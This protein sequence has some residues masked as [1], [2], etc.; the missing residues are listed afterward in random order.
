MNK[1]ALCLLSVSLAIS[2]SSAQNIPLPGWS[3]S[4]GGQ[5]N[6]SGSSSEPTQADLNCFHFP[7]GFLSVYSRATSSNNITTVTSNTVYQLRCLAKVTGPG[8]GAMSLLVD[9]AGTSGTSIPTVANN[10]PLT[11]YSTS[12]TTGGPTDARV[13]LPLKAEFEVSSGLAGGGAVGAFTNITLTATTLIP[14]LQIRNTNANHVAIYWPSNF[15]W[16]VLESSPSLQP[17]SWVGVTNSTFVQGTNLV[18][19]VTADA[20]TRQFRLRQ[21]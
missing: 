16:Y 11:L 18:V 4:G 6:Y 12:F 17:P 1:S 19:I 15:T 14:Q 3:F 5:G 10:V 9:G 13:G 8:S 20:Q 21:P 2:H 7:S